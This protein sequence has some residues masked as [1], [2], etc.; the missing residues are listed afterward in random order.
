M[1]AYLASLFF[2]SIGACFE[3][4]FSMRFRLRNDALAED[5]SYH[6]AISPS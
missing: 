2:L 3:N 1:A 4:D 5:S 6:T